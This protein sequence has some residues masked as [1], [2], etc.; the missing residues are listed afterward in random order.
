[1]PV[2]SYFGCAP[3]LAALASTR[4]EGV[5]YALHSVGTGEH[6]GVGV[7]CQFFQ[8]D[9]A[10]VR[11]WRVPCLYRQSQLRT[12]FNTTV[13]CLLS[14]ISRLAFCGVV[15]TRINLVIE[16][17]HGGFARDECRERQ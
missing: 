7:Q 11:S 6:A 14:F 13:H 8:L 16:H 1:M 17:L 9:H 15:S 12:V 4:G 10:G 2:T 5:V 3:A